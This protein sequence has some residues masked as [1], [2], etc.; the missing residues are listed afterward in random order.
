MPRF[1]FNSIYDN[2][3]QGSTM[4]SSKR[5]DSKY[6]STGLKFSLKGHIWSL[7][8]WLNSAIVVRNS[9]IVVRKQPSTMPRWIGVG[10]SFTVQDTKQTWFG[11]KFSFI[12]IICGL[13]S[14]LHLRIFPFLSLS[15]LSFSLIFFFF[16]HLWQS[17]KLLCYNTEIGREERLETK[18]AAEN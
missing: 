7:S 13:Q 17:Y 6:F 1:F 15:Y 8:K 16:L 5:L 9:A 18:R 12:L 11:L 14:F 4:F 3:V 2:I 10:A